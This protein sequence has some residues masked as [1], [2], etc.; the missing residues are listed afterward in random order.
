MNTK[1]ILCSLVLCLGFWTQTTAQATYTLAEASKVEV[2]GTSNISEWVV[3]VTAMTGEIVLSNGFT[4]RKGP[5][6]GDAIEQAHLEFPVGEMKSGKG[7][8]MDDNIYEAFQKDKHP[9]IVFDL[10]QG[11]VVGASENKVNVRCQGT[12]TMAGQTHPVSLSLEGTRS[13]EGAYT[14]QG[15]HTL[16]MTQWKMVPPTA[17]FGAIEAGEEVTLSF[18]LKLVEKA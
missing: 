10:T 5:K 16:N 17:M 15:K 11:A 4:K 14:F 2:A 18:T 7:E 6:A 3:P 8:T 9:T 1:S 13:D 12:L